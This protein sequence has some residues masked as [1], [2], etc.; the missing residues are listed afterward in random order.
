M[1]KTVV[2]CLFMLMTTA[3]KLTKTTGQSILSRPD[4][5]V[6]GHYESQENR[7]S[8]QNIS[9]FKKGTNS[10]EY[11]ANFS[12]PFLFKVDL[13]DAASIF[14]DIAKNASMT[15][16]SIQIGTSLRAILIV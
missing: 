9:F 12:L 7:T 2:F 3:L 15:G 13:D 6:Q 16:Q 14:V 10:Q 4:R 8:I 11:A 5:R 1:G